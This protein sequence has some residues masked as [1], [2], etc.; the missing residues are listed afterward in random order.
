MKIIKLALMFFYNKEKKV[1]LQDRRDIS[2]R[3]E[4]WGFFGGHIEEG[5]TPEQAII[6]EIKEELSFDLKEFK[7]INHFKN[8]VK[9]FD[10]LLDTHI[11]IAPLRD[12]LKKFKQIEGQGMK[13]F[14]F[15]ETKK[16]KMVSGDDK[17][18]RIA[19]EA[20]KQKHF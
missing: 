10:T 12:N 9:E 3:G 2:K 5:E 14:S 11:F 18:I 16:L 6:R 15:E 17:I 7:F 19:L 4:E 20:I 8:P 13:M 1:L